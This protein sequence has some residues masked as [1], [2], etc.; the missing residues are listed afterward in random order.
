MTQNYPKN[1][2]LKA[3]RAVEF[4]SHAARCASWI[5]TSSLNSEMDIY[6]SEVNFAMKVP[7]NFISLYYRR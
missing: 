4:A 3:R 6:C 2:D 7:I 1:F 5:L